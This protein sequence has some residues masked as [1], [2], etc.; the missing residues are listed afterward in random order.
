MRLLKNSLSCPSTPL[1]Y[2]QGERSG[3]A[4]LGLAVRAELSPQGEVEA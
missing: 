1:R 2:A 3:F 4:S